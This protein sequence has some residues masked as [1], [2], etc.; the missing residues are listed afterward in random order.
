VEAKRSAVRTRFEQ[1]GTRRA[2]DYPLPQDGDGRLLHPVLLATAAASARPEH[3]KEINLLLVLDL[4]RTR[5]VLSRAD[6]VRLTGI[7][8]PTVSKIAQRLVDVGLIAE[9]G[10][11]PSTGG[12]RPNL[13]RFNADVGFVLGVDLGGTHLRCA[14]AS[15][16][17]TFIRQTVAEVDAAAGPEAI[18]A[19]IAERGTALLAEAGARAP[20]AVGV[21]TP[22]V[23]NVET[24]RVL[25]ARN[26]RG[27]QDVPVQRALCEAFG[28]PVAIENDVNAAAVGERWHGAGRGHDTMVFVSVGTGIGAGVIIDGRVHRGTHF[29]AGE[30]NA[31]PAGVVLAGREPWLEDVA[32]G[33][34]IVR[35]ARAAGLLLPDGELTTA[36]V[37]EAAAQ[38]DPAAVQ[39]LAEA[40]GALA[41]GVAALVASIDPA[42]VI[43]GGGVS[44]AGEALVGPLRQALGALMPLRAALAPSLL[45]VD[46]QLHGAVFSALRLG[47]EFLV[48]QTRAAGA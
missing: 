14:V 2:P 45:G 11:G 30:I 5:G 37:F 38:G 31:L 39:A 4:F 42:I 3:M 13:L 32:S 15:L 27:W 7:S 26:L 34:A 21:V 40:V 10:S 28:A 22:G 44:R 48:E 23:V 24:G 36:L 19:E 17:G 46:A 43:F 20:V 33:P 47:D 16:D 18:L 12:K 41:R 9:E 35:R 1:N 29:A 8:A 6:V 25:R